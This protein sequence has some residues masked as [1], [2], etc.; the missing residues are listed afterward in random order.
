MKNSARLLATIMV[1]LTAGSFVFA[2]TFG[3]GKSYQ[4]TLDFVTVGDAGNTANNGIGTV[5]YNYRIMKTELTVDQWVA[6]DRALGLYLSNQG[7]NPVSGR[8]L[9]EIA[10]YCN[11]LH[12]G[13]NQD[14]NSKLTGVYNISNDGLHILP[15]PSA[16][17]WVN[18][19]GSKNKWR[20]RGAKYFL[21]TRDE[22]YKAGFYKAGSTNAGYWTYATRSDA[23]PVAENAS[24]GAN[25]ANY[26]GVVGSIVPVGSYP[27]SISAYGTLDQ[28]GNVWE[29][30]E[31]RASATDDYSYPGWGGCYIYGAQW[32]YA[33]IDFQSAARYGDVGLRI[34]ANSPSTATPVFTP[35]G[36][37]ISGPTA[38]TMTCPT[39]GVN[40]YYTT[41][42]SV[43]T[44]GSTQYTVPI[45]VNHGTILQAIAVGVDTSLAT[46]R[47]YVVAESYADTF[48][49]GTAYQ[50]TLDFVMVGDASNVP[51]GNG[52]GAVGY[53]Y[54]I[55]K[56]ELT[57][58]QWV[59]PDRAFGNPVP[60]Q[61]NNPVGSRTLVE[62]A[63]YCNWLHNGATMDGNTM[64]T[65]VYNISNG[66]LV[67][68]PETDQWVNPDGSKNKW[69]HAGAKY[70][71]PTES[72]LF[73]AGFYKTGSTNAGYWTYA[74]QS[75]V[76][77][78][79]QNASTGVNSANYANIVGSVVPVG[80]YP[81]S[82]SAYG[83]LDQ[84]GNVW[85][86]TEPRATAADDYSYPGWGGCY[87]HAAQWLYNYLD[88]QSTVRY[89][90]VGLRIAA[91]VP[92][93]GMHWVRNNDFTLMAAVG[94]RPNFTHEN[95]RPERYSQASMSMF[96]PWAYEYEN[97]IPLVNA[98]KSANMPWHKLIPAQAGGLT[99]Q[100]KLD[101][102]YNSVV[103]GLRGFYVSDE[104]SRLD[105][106]NIAS[107]MQWLRQTLPSSLVYTNLTPY[108]QPDERYY[109]QTPPAG[110][111]NYNQYLND[112]IAIV[113]P[114]VLMYDNYPF[115]GNG[116]TDN[117]FPNMSIIRQK[118]LDA[119]I[120]Y[121]TWIQS[122]T[123]NSYYRTPSVTDLR[124]QVYSHLAYGYTGIAYFTY[125]DMIGPAMVLN[126]DQQTPTQVYL[127][128][129]SL[130]VEVANLGKT[131][132]NLKSTGVGYVPGNH[133]ET[134][135]DSW[136]IFHLFPLTRV[137]AN[138]IPEGI[139]LWSANTGGNSNIVSIGVVASGDANNGMIG[140]FTEDD[141]RQ[142]FMLAN[143]KHASDMTV[144][145]GALEFRIQFNS[146][147]NEISRVNSLTGQIEVLPLNNH[148]LNLTLGGGTG[149]LFMF[150]ITD[151]NILIPSPGDAN[152]DGAVDVGDL[153][154]LA[155]NYGQ[156][157]RTGN[158]PQTQWWSV[159]DFNND[160]QVDVGD[161]GILAAHYGEGSTTQLIDFNA[162][163][164]KVFGTTVNEG[165]E[166]D[167]A[168][169]NSE[170]SA[171]GLPLIAS[172]MLA[173]LL[174]LGSS[175]LEN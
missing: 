58:D 108:G 65:G 91:A 38:I 104:P 44:T 10:M 171:L 85:E 172:L 33:S 63:Q 40:I 96:L 11:W 141:G 69:R 147:I 6:L 31:P 64:L 121:W 56:T 123:D 83:T 133:N 37:Y 72:E 142:Y 71:L 122:F 5:G 145:A 173:G 77:P 62:M 42:G 50:F 138:S 9:V 32:L 95:F 160:G 17:Q 19:N 14:G 78:V 114:D 175:K 174:L 4:F 36:K 117:F 129:Q 120:P 45:T 124:M 28:S 170:C 126:D 75:D 153:G 128:I 22:W 107:A 112:V 20:H 110:G 53:N 132:K 115:R 131:L 148:I 79:A 105:M 125:N 25:S 30:T 155:A 97:S 3:T 51:A 24:A 55:M 49:R 7:K 8:T 43:P 13:A 149:E 76:T 82:I 59:A 92:V 156:D 152:S 134:Y 143:L 161:L 68:W 15:W 74:T 2:D 127:D 87:I 16:D 94:A 48:G 136:D 27:N 144:A 169:A 29:T 158:V 116:S 154:I 47:T 100:M 1:L 61:G 98:N 157:L 86:A 90:D 80:S 106:E 164:A 103:P 113:K 21:P 35:D 23:V 66:R 102:Q 39:S 135:Y 118:A 81:N 12:N 139:G 163:Y 34:A 159:G 101:I 140:F 165:I 73:K 54:R 18:P 150:D 146:A 88:F 99:D 26:G 151:P 130:N 166:N 60:P 67:P 93:G 168:I 111:Y 57:V 52:L 89:G 46:S 137:V 162:D 41:D 119:G 70:F 84:S 167:S 109:G